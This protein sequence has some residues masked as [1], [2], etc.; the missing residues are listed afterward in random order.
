MAVGCAGLFIIFV[1]LVAFG[2]SNNSDNSVTL[3]TRTPY[4]TRT[5]HP[6]S[7]LIC[8]KC[9]DMTSCAQSKRCLDAGYTNLDS[10]ND[11]VPCESICPGG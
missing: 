11:G 10:D 5:P 2:G 1:L 8:G 6:T 9:S 3:P 4:P 7:D